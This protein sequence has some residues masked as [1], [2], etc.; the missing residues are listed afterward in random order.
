MLVRLDPE[1]KSISMLSLPR[2]LR[3]LIPG[4]ATTR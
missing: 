4:S 3:V 2:D 1:T